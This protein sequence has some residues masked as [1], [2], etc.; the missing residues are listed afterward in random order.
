MN[1]KYSGVYFRISQQRRIL[2]NWKAQKTPKGSQPILKLRAQ[3]S[4]VG[5]L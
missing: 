2:R 5:A 3:E 4:G 1:S